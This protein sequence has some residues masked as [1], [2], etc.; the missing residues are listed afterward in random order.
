MQT[1]PKSR[2]L[3]HR[4]LGQNALSYWAGFSSADQIQ[5]ESNDRSPSRDAEDALKPG[6]ASTDGT[7]I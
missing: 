5:I 1:A 4:R 6:E 2:P 7:S 3:L